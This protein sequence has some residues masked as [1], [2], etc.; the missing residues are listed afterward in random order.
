MDAGPPLHLI[1]ASGY[2][3]V[4]VRHVLLAEGTVVKPV[5]A[6]PA[7]DHR[8][9]RYSDFESGMRIDKGHQRSE[10]VVGDAKDADLA[11]GFGNIFNEPVDGVVSVGG[12]IDG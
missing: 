3:F 9:H 1:L 8:I 10:A 6:H 11:V 7:V 4:D 12:V 5:V 2:L